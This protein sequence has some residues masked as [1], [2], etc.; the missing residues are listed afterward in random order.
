MLSP[1]T[2]F[3]TYFIFF[4]EVNFMNFTILTLNVWGFFSR[5]RVVFSKNKQIN[6]G[7]K[8]FTE[9]RQINA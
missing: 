5:Y 1:V 9:I 4:G 8:D 2:F 6:T 7:T 3:S